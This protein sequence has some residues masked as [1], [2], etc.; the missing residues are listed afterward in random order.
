MKPLVTG[1]K[2]PWQNPFVER[3][4]GTI[5][6]ECLDHLIPLSERHL[7]RTLRERGASIVLYL[8]KIQTADEAAFWNEMLSSLERHLDLPGGTIKVAR[9]SSATLTTVAAGPP[10]STRMPDTKP[11]PVSSA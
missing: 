11:R 9:V 1:Y 10:T 4:I 5:R 8:P 2:C 7:L 3:V 6:R